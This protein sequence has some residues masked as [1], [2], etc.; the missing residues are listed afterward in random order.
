MPQIPKSHSPAPL[1][2]SSRVVL[3]DSA[4]NAALRAKIERAAAQRARD[5]FW[6]AV[7]ARKQPRVVR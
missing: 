5:R 7:Q 1:A 4:E 6:L 2:L 3:T